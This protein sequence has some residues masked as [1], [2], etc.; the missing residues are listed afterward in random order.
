MLKKYKCKQFITILPF[1]ARVR[2]VKFIFNYTEFLRIDEEMT[3]YRPE[4]SVAL[5]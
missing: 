2:G 3:F 1:V 4:A 5:I